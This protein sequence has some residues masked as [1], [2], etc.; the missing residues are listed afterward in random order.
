MR[1][2]FKQ[3]LQQGLAREWNDSGRLIFEAWYAEGAPDGTV[4]T[5]YP[6][7]QL[8]SL[9]FLKRALSKG[10][11]ASTQMGNSNGWPIIGRLACWHTREVFFGWPFTPTAKSAEGRPSG[12]FLQYF[13]DLNAEGAHPLAKRGF[14]QEGKLHGEQQRFFFDGSLQASLG[15]DH[16]VLHGKK[17]LWDSGGELREEVFYD[18]GQL[19]GRYYLK[20]PNGI[21]LIS[22]YHDNKLEGLHQVYYPRHPTYGRV[23]ALEATFQNGQLEG[24]LAQFNPE[25]AKI[26]SAPYSQGRRGGILTLYADD[27]KVLFTAEFSGDLQ[28]GVTREYYPN[29]Q[30]FKQAFF[31]N[32]FKEGEEITYHENGVCKAL[33]VYQKGLLEG[34]YREWTPSGVLIYEADYHQ[35]QK[36]G[37]LVKIQRGGAA[38]LGNAV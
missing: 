30:V 36:N 35:G 28:H 33:A 9:T 10:K 1:C 27:G 12:E 4:K 37:R 26:F 22:H 16:G 17:A 13:P 14:Y 15:Y 21:E 32:D 19:E 6:D 18:H 29:G 20:K 24:E 11:S 8:Q 23:K 25:G 2:T 3:G 38:A 7:G 31:Q 5:W 34:S